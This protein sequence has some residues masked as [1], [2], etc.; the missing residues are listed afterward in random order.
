MIDIKKEGKVSVL[1]GIYNCE[2]TLPQAI[3]AIQRQ[4]YKNWELIICDDGS[5]DDS[6]H[7]AQQFA[8]ND[9]R[10]IL[11]KNKSNLGLNKTLNLCLSHAT[12]EFIAR[13]DGDDD[14]SEERFEKQICFLK[15]QNDY[16]IVSSQMSFFDEKGVWGYTKKTEI[17]TKED[18]V[19][20][21]PICHAPVM[22]YKKCMDAV[23]GYTEDI[24]M[25]RVEDVNLWIKLYTAGF[26][27]YNLPEALYYMR[28]DKNAFSRR[29]YKYRINSTYVRL[30]GCKALRLAPQYYVKAFSPMIVGLVP[31]FVRRII[32][33]YLIS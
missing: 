6:Y 30:L 9:T 5:S 15:S 32:K 12:G 2:Q 13:M 14:C 4:T 28:N 8:N 31:N 23:G 26:R 19:S 7:V 20:G 16:Q 10:I 3:K 17:P 33:K 24:R 1:M 22:M 18:V 27:C 29:K 25:I 11:L 21:S